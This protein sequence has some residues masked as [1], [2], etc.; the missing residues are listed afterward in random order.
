MPAILAL[1]EVELKVDAAI[2]EL[3]MERDAGESLDELAA[4]K[5]EESSLDVGEDCGERTDQSR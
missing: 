5:S 1:T 4:V 3:E 2:I